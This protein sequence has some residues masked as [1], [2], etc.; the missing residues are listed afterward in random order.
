M[1]KN[2]SALR[3]L[4]FLSRINKGLVLKRDNVFKKKKTCTLFELSIEL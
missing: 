2:P 3:D 1:N 4:K